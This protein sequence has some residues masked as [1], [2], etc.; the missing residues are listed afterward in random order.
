MINDDNDDDINDIT[1]YVKHLCQPVINGPADVAKIL[2]AI[3]YW[4]VNEIPP[5]IILYFATHLINRAEI[6]FII[7]EEWLCLFTKLFDLYSRLMEKIP[8]MVYF[9]YKPCIRIDVYK[10]LFNQILTMHTINTPLYGIIRYLI[11]MASYYG[12]LD[13]LEFVYNLLMN[14]PTIDLAYT[15][16]N[17]NFSEYRS[18]AAIH[19]RN[20][21]HLLFNGV[22]DWSITGKHVHCLKYA[23]DNMFSWDEFELARNASRTG[24]LE[25]LQ[26]IFRNKKIPDHYPTH[27]DNAN[28]ELCQGAAGCGQYNCLKF[29]HENGCPWD[30]Y[31]CEA[32]ASYCFLECLKYLIEN[33]CPCDQITCVEKVVSSGQLTGQLECLKYL[34]MNGCPLTINTCNKAVISNQLD[35][36]VYLHQN[37][38]PWN[39]TTWDVACSTWVKE[40]WDYIDHTGHIDDIG[41]QIAKERLACFI[42]LYEQNCPC[43]NVEFVYAI[44]LYTQNNGL[45]NI[46][47]EENKWTCVWK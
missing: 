46:F 32:A 9:D 34:H 16:D 36:L 18:S 12:Q 19:H 43:D 10:V 8:L 40:K 30:E 37:N 4:D 39:S 21:V 27:C 41:T 26:F 22:S 35:C 17:G 47:Y 11:N 45:P 3:Q 25:G 31:T 15:V 38:C 23:Q 29:L 2:G 42:Y 28:A 13:C 1:P 44:G 20:C 7:E 24:F 14:E 33:G 6:D 5:N